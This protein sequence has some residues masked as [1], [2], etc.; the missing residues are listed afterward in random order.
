MSPKQSA[1]EIQVQKDL[2]DKD[3]ISTA[4]EDGKTPLKLFEK[5]FAG[6]VKEDGS[7]FTCF[8]R[9]AIEEFFDRPGDITPDA[10][11]AIEEGAKKLGVRGHKMVGF[12]YHPN[13]KTPSIVFGYI[14]FQNGKTVNGVMRHMEVQLDLVKTDQGWRINKYTE[15]RGY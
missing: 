2:A 1:A 14:Y 10:L 13:N 5:F 7:E 6:M 4:P 9:R 3:A 12:W 11:K 8:T 15:L